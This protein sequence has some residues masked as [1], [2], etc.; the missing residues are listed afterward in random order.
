MLYDINGTKVGSVYGCDCEGTDSAYRINGKYAFPV[1]KVMSYNVRW[2]E[3]INSQQAMQSQI[4]DGYDADLIGLQEISYNGKIPTVGANVLG[5][6]S[7]IKLSNHKNYLAVASKNI[8]LSDFTASDF[9]SQDPDDATE[10][11]ETR[12]YTKCYIQFNG[13]HIC[14]INTHLAVLNDSYKY[15]QMSEVFT[16]AESEDYVI[17]TGDFNSQHQTFSDSDYLNMYKMFVDAGYNLITNSPTSGIV[18]THSTST[19]VTSLREMSTPTDCIIVSGNIG[20][21]DSVFDTTKFSYLDGNPIDHI[22]MV[23]TLEVT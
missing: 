23:A 16:M 21:S 2:F 19:F 14:W 18:R 17:I 22:A 9:V 7:T 12:A 15:A 20:I 8:E 13:K 6:Y 4:I 11:G 3:E 1:L 10:Y 5:A